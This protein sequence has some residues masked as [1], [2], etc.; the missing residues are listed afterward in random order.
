MNLIPVGWGAL[1][2]E[3]EKLSSTLRFT[4]PKRTQKRIM[5]I[6]PSYVCEQIIMN[7][8]DVPKRLSM[9]SNQFLKNMRVAPHK[10]R[11]L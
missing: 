9:V 3:P 7:M 5:S 2:L 11:A 8:S 1:G 6:G 4:V 10:L